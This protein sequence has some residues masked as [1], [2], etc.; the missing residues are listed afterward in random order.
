MKFLNHEIN[1]IQLFMKAQKN[2]ISSTAILI[3]TGTSSAFARNHF[4]LED[5][6]L[7]KDRRLGPQMPDVSYFLSVYW[8]SNSEIISE[9]SKIAFA[10][11]I[12]I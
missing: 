11:K 10:F 7:S 5:F 8:S 2:C 4:I 1:L 6:K 3:S 12:M 9:L